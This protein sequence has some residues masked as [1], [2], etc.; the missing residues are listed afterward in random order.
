M[1]FSETGTEALHRYVLTQLT[2]YFEVQHFLHST[3][4]AGS[5]EKSCKTLEKCHKHFLKSHVES[6]LTIKICFIRRQA[7]MLNSFTCR[8]RCEMSF[9]LQFSCLIIIAEIFFYNNFE[10]NFLNDRYEIFSEGHG[11]IIWCN[12]WHRS[13]VIAKISLLQETIDFYKIYFP[14]S[15]LNLDDIWLNF[16]SS[17]EEIIFLLLQQLFSKFMSSRRLLL[18]ALLHGEMCLCIM[19]EITVWK[20]TILCFLSCFLLLNYFTITC[21]TLLIVCHVNYFFVVAKD[22]WA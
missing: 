11:K 19:L 13:K 15:C 16:I 10:L 20:Q 6:A 4:P 18:S 17:N 5:R 3:S 22:L 12:K 9:Y 14:A 1:Q 21:E 2:R 7:E 8:F